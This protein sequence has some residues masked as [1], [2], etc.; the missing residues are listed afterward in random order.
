MIGFTGLFDTARDYIFQFII[1]H[2]RTHAH[3][4]THTHTQTNVYSHVFTIRCSVAASK[5]GRSPSFGF[6]NCP[7]ASATSFSQQRL[8][9]TESQQL[10][11]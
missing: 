11:N 9:T 7:R 1:T 10:S 4:H 5:G 2:A 6:P 8:T 3:T